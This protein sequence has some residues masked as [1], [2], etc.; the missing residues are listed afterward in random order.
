MLPPGAWSSAIPPTS[1]STADSFP[2]HAAARRAPVGRRALMSGV[3]GGASAMR[4]PA[5]EDMT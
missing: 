2:L 3:H 5:P 1:P 4:A